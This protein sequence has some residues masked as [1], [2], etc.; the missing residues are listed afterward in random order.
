MRIWDIVK[1]A[2]SLLF[3]IQNMEKF[4]QATEQMEENMLPIIMAGILAIVI[5]ISLC[6]AAVYLVLS[7][8]GLG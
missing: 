5:F 1:Q 8:A 7:S 3:Q 6:I 2:F 4:S